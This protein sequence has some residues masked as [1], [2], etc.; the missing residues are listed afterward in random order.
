MNIFY[1]DED[2]IKAAQGLPDKLIV[3]MPL[4]SA[5]ML[6]SA[7][8]ILDGD[9]AVHQDV[10]Y[11]LTHKN[12]P[13][14]VWVREGSANYDWLYVHFMALCVEYTNRYE[15][16]HL[17]QSKLAQILIHRPKNIASTEEITPIAKCVPERYLQDCPV[18]SYREYLQGTKHYAKWDR[19]AARRPQWWLRVPSKEEAEINMKAI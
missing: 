15:K 9:S 11:K 10:I 4:E 7:H 6:S 5:Q 12:H 19:I 17:C 3:K 16:I 2:P 14:S 1:V 13:S 8:R 18:T